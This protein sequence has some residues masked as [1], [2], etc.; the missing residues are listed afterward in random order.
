MAESF[1][2]P[3]DIARLA[4]SIATVSAAVN[5]VESKVDVVDSNVNTVNE[6]VRLVYT[7]I[8]Q[9]ARD[10][11]QYVVKAER[12]HQL[13]LA[14]TRLGN[15]QEDLERKYGHYKVVRRSTTQILRATDAGIVKTETIE[16]ISEEMY[17]QAGQ[18]WLT[19]CL[20]GLASWIG[21]KQEIAEKAVKQA[22]ALDE[23]KTSLL[24]G[25]ICRRADRQDAAIKWISRYLGRQNP[26]A[27]HREAIVV[28]DAYSAGLFYSETDH[29]IGEQIA[30][31]LEQLVAEPGFLEEETETWKTAL[32]DRK[33]PLPADEFEYLE[34][35]SKTWPQLKDLM[36]GA[37]LHQ[38]VLDYFE[39]ILATVSSRGAIKA[40]LDEIMDQLV[41]S[42]DDEELPLQ[43]EI[44][45]CQ[46][47]IKYEGDV[48]RAEKAI[49]AEKFLFNKTTSFTELLT[50]AVM[51]PDEV[52]ASPS[53]QKLAL[54]MS[55]EWISDSYSQLVAENRTRIPTEIEINIDTFNDA[56]KD[57]SDEDRLIKA[58]NDHIDLE[59]RAEL[60]KTKLNPGD[61]YSGIAGAALGII[62]V[63]LFTISS[64]AKLGVQWSFIGLAMFIVG[65]VLA[66]R[67]YGKEKS[68]KSRRMQI[69]K[70]LEEKRALGATILRAVIAEIVDFMDEF[71]IADEVGDD[72]VNMLE[73]LNPEE[74]I[75]AIS[76]P[77]RTVSLKA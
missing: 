58:F 63:L 1:I 66:F 54:A 35:F 22:L 73:Q 18:Y 51:Y 75:S 3:A 21:D 77:V 25:L 38:D 44:N 14:T 43:E 52:S 61:L 5:Q 20:V 37:R 11:Q 34:Q 39:G 8:E 67:Y 70:D 12:Q 23:N 24:F 15:L 4:T 46:Q 47:I 65:G 17:I 13:E 31:W 71:E 62:G 32:N 9:L 72:V 64:V 10:F 68:A 45:E 16:N 33:Q 53:T 28:L 42:Y 6:N 29:T 2:T 27:L 74:Y 57:G 26:E 60:E 41:S 7:D 48:D 36:E 55:R 40:Q 19:P 59:K 56:T 76:G 30:M 50:K 49:E 69:E